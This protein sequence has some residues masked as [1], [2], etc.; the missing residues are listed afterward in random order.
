MSQDN[1]QTARGD[2]TAAD[3]FGRNMSERA[4]EQADDPSGATQR[5]TLEGGHAADPARSSIPDE[6]DNENERESSQAGAN[7][8]RGLAAEDAMAD[9][10]AE[11]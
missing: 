10:K 4:Q 6:E 8:T 1:T 7:S 2:D 5:V 9:G 11:G 3:A